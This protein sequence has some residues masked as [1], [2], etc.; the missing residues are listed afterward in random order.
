M[1]AANEKDEPAMT[2]PPK[3]KRTGSFLSRSLLGRSMTTLIM[4]TALA[5]LTGSLGGWIMLSEV[6]ADQRI[7]E[8][9]GRSRV[10]VAAL[11]DVYTY[12]AVETGPNGMPERI[13]TDK[14][15]GDEAS[16]LLTGLDPAD[17]AMAV[18]QRAFGETWL[19]GKQADG[20]F[21][22]LVTS[23]RRATAG[24]P[25]TVADPVIAMMA[26]G[27][28]AVGFM[29]LSGERHFVSAI[30][31]VT[32]AGGVIGA[33]IISAGQEAQL[34]QAEWA[35]TRNA[36]LILIVTLAAA[37]LVGFYSFRRQFRP[38]PLLI[39]STQAIA[40][41][42]IDTRVR[43]QS[44]ID[45]L[46]ALARA[47]E[48]LR[49]GM[50]DRIRLREAEEIQRREAE[51]RLTMDSAIARFRTEID[52]ALAET[53][54]SGRQVRDMSGSLGASVGN[55]QAQARSVEGAASEAS[56]N[57]ASVAGSARALSQMI[58]TIAARADHSIEVVNRSRQIGEQSRTRTADLVK[59]ADQIGSAVT[60]IRQIAEQTNLLAL[61]AT[62][63]A[64]RAGDAGRGFAVV[65]S[66]VKT[67]ATQSAE[68][69]NGIA[70]QVQGIQTATRQVVEAAREME[71]V[72]ADIGAVSHQIADAV[73][74]QDAATGQ[75]AHAAGS[76]ED[77]MGGI[78]T[79]MGQIG[80]LIEQT[81]VATAELE[82]IAGALAHSE[83]QLAT[84]ISDFLGTVA[85]TDRTVAA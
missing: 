68:A 17:V 74:Q 23:A 61:N 65:A 55:S 12:V 81:S 9:E 62:I 6:M 77:R 83:D 15:I 42:E 53:R 14:P 67:L 66:E 26:K 80:A 34:R 49:L 63:E 35:L 37:V 22:P 8:A 47:L 45:E 41:E 7:H 25:L 11:R 79:D 39:Q 60:L 58:A 54:K 20:G 18:A 2:T 50:A 16:L 72:L 33:V 3:M 69:T 48:D 30:P 70:E 57:V 4:I 36:L 78:R 32:Q 43:F 40:R 76:A 73:R 52:R 24:F 85:D 56:E 13:K 19:M 38:V 1:A 46:G 21:L 71:G 84:A 5:S 59:A 31:V 75:I 10:A 64:A 82:R 27:S 28:A 51:R 29:T 44:R